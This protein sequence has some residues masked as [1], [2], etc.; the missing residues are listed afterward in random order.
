M[1]MALIDHLERNQCNNLAF[2][3]IYC[4]SANSITRYLEPWGFKL[5]QCPAMSKKVNVEFYFMF[6][7]LTLFTVDE[8]RGCH[9]QGDE[10]A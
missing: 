8:G 10:E 3:H 6:Y 1:S 4:K 9:N 7:Q 5:S 2:E